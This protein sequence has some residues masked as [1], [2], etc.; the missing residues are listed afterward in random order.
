MVR[1]CVVG[2]YY[3]TLIRTA[4]DKARPFS[5]G[6]G[7]PCGARGARCAE[8]HGGAA[9]SLP[10]AGREATPPTDWSLFQTSRA[11]VRAVLLASVSLVSVETVGGR[12][13][14]GDNGSKA[15]ARSQ[16]ELVL[17]RFQPPSTRS[18]GPPSSAEDLQ[19]LVSAV[20]HQQLQILHILMNMLRLYFN[21]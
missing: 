14:S 17:C 1:T 5:A 8:Q 6:T 3:L 15:P 11:P 2:L 12:C 13:N 16:T 7:L 10:G 20:T 18:S 9:E 4:L 21:W 19:L